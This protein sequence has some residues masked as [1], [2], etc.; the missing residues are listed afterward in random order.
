LAN[1]FRIN[2]PKITAGITPAGANKLPIMAANWYP[3]SLSLS[4]IKTTCLC[5]YFYNEYHCF[6]GFNLSLQNLWT[7]FAQSNFF[8]LGFT[9]VESWAIV[10]WKAGCKTCFCFFL[11]YLHLN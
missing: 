6:Q 7:Y 1:K 3:I 10:Y 11:S 9:C 2:N 8:L 5:D 4:S